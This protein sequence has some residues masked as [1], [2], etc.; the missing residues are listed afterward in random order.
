[1]TGYTLSGELGPGRPHHFMIRKA[2]DEDAAAVASVYLASRKRHVA[3]APPA[4][5]DAEIRNWIRQLLIPKSRV[6]VVEENGVIVAM[7]ALTAASDGGWI[8][9]LY[10]A[11]A[12]TGRGHGTALVDFAQRELPSPISV[13]TFQQNHRSRQFYERRGFLA[14]RFSDG[15]TNE[16]RCPDVLYRWEPASG[17]RE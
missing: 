11:P 13:Y 10:V 17:K 9:Q 12:S 16:E 7:M 5:P 6:V 8:D 2:T 4:H 3:F 15:S 14:V 1:M